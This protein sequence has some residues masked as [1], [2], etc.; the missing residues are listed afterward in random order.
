MVVLN[1]CFSNWSWLLVT[2]VAQWFVTNVLRDNG[3]AVFVRLS[4]DM[5]HQRMRLQKEDPVTFAES[6]RV[7]LCFLRSPLDIRFFSS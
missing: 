4:F 3:P 6:T 2:S 5:V 1:A 7:I